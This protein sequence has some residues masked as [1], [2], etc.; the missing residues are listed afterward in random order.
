MS[1]VKFLRGNF[2]STDTSQHYLK[3]KLSDSSHIGQG[4]FA[5]PLLRKSL[6]A[7]KLPSLGLLLIKFFL[8]CLFPVR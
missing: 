6:Q 7:I 3:L 8:Y 5:L 1:D 4:F 2:D